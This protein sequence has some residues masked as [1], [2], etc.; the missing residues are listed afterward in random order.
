MLAFLL[1]AARACYHIDAIPTD[2]TFTVDPNACFAFLNATVFR[3]ANVT[4]TIALAEHCPNTFFG[5]NH[6][7]EKVLPE[8][9][10]VTHGEV[11]DSE[12]LDLAAFTRPI[13]VLCSPHVEKGDRE[14]VVLPEGVETEDGLEVTLETELEEDCDA[15]RTHFG[16]AGN[17][18]HVVRHV[19]ELEFGA[20]EFEVA[21]IGLGLVLGIVII[22]ACILFLTPLI[23]RH[24]VHEEARD[25]LPSEPLEEGQLQGPK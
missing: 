22:A 14:L 20:S 8:S 16:S 21:A 6:S 2:A 1:T 18:I 13:P 3:V 24:A 25:L 11:G 17:C 9:V 19:P 12:E 7:D 4:V 15:Y 23:H 10:V 5:L